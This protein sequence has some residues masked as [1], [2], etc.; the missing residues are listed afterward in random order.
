MLEPEEKEVTPGFPT[1]DDYRNLFA[2]LKAGFDKLIGDTIDDEEE[3]SEM[4]DVADLP[5]LVIHYKGTDNHTDVHIT[6]EEAKKFIDA[7]EAKDTSVTICTLNSI[8]G[9][10]IR[11]IDLT[12][13]SDWKYFQD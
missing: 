6:D 5:S 1:K 11:G 13:V 7:W 12:S 3:D 4:I 2:T 8:Y 9:K 10:E